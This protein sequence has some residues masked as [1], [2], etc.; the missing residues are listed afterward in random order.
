VY[1]GTELPLRLFPRAHL[2]VQPGKTPSLQWAIARPAGSDALF[3]AA[4][5]ANGNCL[6]P[7][8]SARGRGFFF[9]SEDPYA[10]FQ[11]DRHCKLD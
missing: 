1:P 6:T 3:I 11:L 7:V 2:L 5:S 9:N 8:A 4:I 10:P